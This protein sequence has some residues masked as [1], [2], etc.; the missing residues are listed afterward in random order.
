M[1]FFGANV[2]EAKL[3]AEVLQV[4]IWHIFEGLESQISSELLTALA[5]Y[6]ACSDVTL[7]CAFHLCFIFLA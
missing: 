2:T 7:N 1:V 5:R 4:Y 6:H 3:S